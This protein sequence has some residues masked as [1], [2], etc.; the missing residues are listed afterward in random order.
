M[1]PFFFAFLKLICWKPKRKV[2]MAKCSMKA[3]R[4]LHAA[5]FTEKAWSIKDLF[6]IYLAKQES[7]HAGSRGD[8][9]SPILP[10]QVAN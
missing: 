10:A 2:K 6:F 3:T 1:T 9:I 5:V 4:C 8:K 7:F